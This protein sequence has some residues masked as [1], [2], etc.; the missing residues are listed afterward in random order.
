MEIIKKDKSDYIGPVVL[1]ATTVVGAEVIAN[2][3]PL[4]LGHPWKL[5]IGAIVMGGGLSLLNSMNY[6]SMEPETASDYMYNNRNLGTA[7]DNNYH[8]NAVVS[9]TVT[10]PRNMNSSMN[11]MGAELQPQFWPE[12]TKQRTSLNF[13]TLEGELYNGNPYQFDQK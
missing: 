13:P 9:T 7:Y 1:V 11:R 5:A 2:S 12:M 6:R 3:L 4:D 10:A 8:P